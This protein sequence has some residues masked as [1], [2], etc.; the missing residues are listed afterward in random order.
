ME[1]GGPLARL[2]LWSPKLTDRVDL[3][4]LI[5]IEFAEPAVVPIHRLH[6]A[7]L[8]L[9]QALGYEPITAHRH[10]L[11]RN[12]HMLFADAQEAAGADH[13]V[14]LAVRPL[15]HALDIAE[16]IALRVVEIEPVDLGDGKRLCP[17]NGPVT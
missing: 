3:D 10:A 7:D 14:L 8:I 12:W 2:P 16:L 15:D 11:Q 4:L 6:C 17:R 9:G 5:A 1:R 13:D